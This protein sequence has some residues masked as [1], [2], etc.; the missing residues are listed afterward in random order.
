M[1]NFDPVA[2]ELPEARHLAHQR[3]RHRAEQSDRPYLR[4][5]CQILRYRIRGLP[6]I[7][8]PLEHVAIL[9][10]DLF[11]RGLGRHGSEPS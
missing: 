4:K 5:F 8:L 9:F 10:S 7:G 11:A 3:Q 6:E 1:E 2:L